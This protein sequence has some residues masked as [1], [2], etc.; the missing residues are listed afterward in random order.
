MSVSVTTLTPSYAR[1][2]FVLIVLL[3]PITAIL[4]LVSR[5]WKTRLFYVY[6][7]VSDEHSFI[8]DR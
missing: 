3:Y 5:L 4:P 2:E 1:G 6:K 8:N 7:T